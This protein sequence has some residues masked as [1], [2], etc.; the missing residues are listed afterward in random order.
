M[1]IACCRLVFLGKIIIFSHQ[2]LLFLQISIE[3]TPAKTGSKVQKRPSNSVVLG[4]GGSA[5][6]ALTCDLH[7]GTGNVLHCCKELVGM[8]PTFKAFLK[9]SV[10]SCCLLGKVIIVLFGVHRLRGKSPC[11]KE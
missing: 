8:N 5:A 3:G 6:E 11:P 1:L 10:S 4:A 7:P 2:I 9:A